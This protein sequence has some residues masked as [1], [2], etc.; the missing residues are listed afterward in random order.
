[1]YLVALRVPPLSSSL[2]SLATAAVAVVGPCRVT[3]FLFNQLPQIA[4]VTI[5]LLQFD[6]YA[7]ISLPLPLLLVMS[8]Y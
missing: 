8:L 6:V 7:R 2:K 3:I 5:F 1:M 4:D